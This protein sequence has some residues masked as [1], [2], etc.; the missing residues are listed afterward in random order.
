MPF[1]EILQML[2]TKTASW[3]K[4]LYQ[5]DYSKQFWGKRQLN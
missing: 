4:L 3:L 5:E 1:M 2:N